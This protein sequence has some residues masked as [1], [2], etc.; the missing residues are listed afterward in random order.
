M[1]VTMWGTNKRTPTQPSRPSLIRRA[2]TM[3]SMIDWRRRVVGFTTMTTDMFGSR[4]WQ[5][6]RVTGAPT[7]TGTGYGRTVAGSGIQTKTSDGPRITMDAG[8]WSPE[9]AGFGCR[10]INGLPGGSHG[11]KRITTIT[12]AGHHCHLRQLSV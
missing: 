12:S 8:L 4:M 11:A 6:R 5:N 3:F 2:P 1:E 7:L 10:A 9:P